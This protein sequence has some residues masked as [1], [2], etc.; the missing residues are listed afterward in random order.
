MEGDGDLTEN[1]I[2]Q[3]L[4]DNIA[5]KPFIKTAVLN[6]IYTE[7]MT[8]KQRVFQF[9]LQRDNDII[10][11]IQIQILDVSGNIAVSHTD[12]VP[13]LKVILKWV[14]LRFSALLS[15]P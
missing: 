12:A 7:K 1:E 15:A 3:T 14:S 6:K 10:P 2:I 9:F 4:L 11:M 8:V 5:D 13:F